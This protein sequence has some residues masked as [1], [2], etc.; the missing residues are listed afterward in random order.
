MNL[1]IITINRNNAT[2]L[3]RTLASTFGAQPGFDDWEQIIVDGASTDNSFDVLDKWKDNPHLGWHVSEP[4]TGIYN[5]MNKG[6]AHAK[7]DYLLFLNAGDELLPDSLSRVFS[8]PFD[9]DIVYGNIVISRVFD[10]KTMADSIW[11]TPVPEDVTP[12]YFF[13]T[14]LPHQA[15]L[16]SR[17]LHEKMGGYDETLRV[18]SDCKFFLDCVVSESAR[19]RHLPFA[20]ARFSEGGV[21]T[22]AQYEEPY[23]TER[24]EMLTPY[25]GR[26]AARRIVHPPERRWLNAHAAQRATRDQAFARCL[27]G[28]VKLF[29]ALWGFRL[30]RAPAKLMLKGHGF[31]VRIVSHRK[32][33]KQHG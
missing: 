30:F 18:F 19:L 2:G 12:A 15:C 24:E 4:D 26:Y 23:L 10:G 32:T 25:V 27:G 28:A 6:A 13:L 5:A 31:I 3:A 20:F 16:V 8:I 21:S 1:S 11:T 17:S 22:K 9:E 14:A 29:D 33:T 7:G